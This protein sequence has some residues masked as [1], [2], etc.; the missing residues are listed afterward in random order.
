MYCFQTSSL[1]AIL[2]K[3]GAMFQDGLGTFKAKIL[4]EEGAQ[5][6]FCKARSVPYALHE[7]FKGSLKT[8]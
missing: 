6:H 4:V 8:W 2:Q 7:K 5:L 1:Q 3:H